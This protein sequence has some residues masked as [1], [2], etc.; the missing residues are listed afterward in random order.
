[1]LCLSKLLVL[2]RLSAFVLLNSRLQADRYRIV[3][4]VNFFTTALVVLG[5]T[6]SSVSGW[7]SAHRSSVVSSH[8][9]D[10]ASSSL[11]FGYNSTVV[12]A[13]V[14]SAI[15]ASNAARQAASIQLFTET[16]TLIIIITMFI[17]GGV[18]A[19]VLMSR[20]S[21]LLENSDTSAPIIASASKA[22]V[23]IMRRIWMTVIGVFIGFLFRSFFDVLYSVSL[24]SDASDVCPQTC[25]PCQSTLYLISKFL[26]YSPYIQ[27]SVVFISE[28]LSLLVALWGMTTPRMWRI[29]VATFPPNSG[30][31]LSTS[32][33]RL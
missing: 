28:P 21:S 19:F 1:L 4:R 14:Q 18:I 10:A 8:Y 3:K 33:S 9:A 23:V 24:T 7:I 6:V 16:A 31:E 26:D 20:A 2:N 11:L 17:F 15:A 25:D 30:R 27:S 12:S 5:G 29:F 13:Y 32:G 22:S